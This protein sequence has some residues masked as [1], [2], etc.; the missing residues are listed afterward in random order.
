MTKFLSTDFPVDSI[1]PYIGFYPESQNIYKDSFPSYDFIEI[2]RYKDT[3]YLAAV[4][5]F[6][7]VV[8][9]YINN[10]K[11]TLESLQSTATASF[12][13]LFDPE[14]D[15]NKTI[16]LRLYTKII[17]AHTALHSLLGNYQHIASMLDFYSTVGIRPRN[18]YK[19]YIDA[20]LVSK[21]NTDIFLLLRKQSGADSHVGYNV[22]LLAALDYCDEASI[23]V[24]NIYYIGYDWNLFASNSKISLS[25]ITVTDHLRQVASRY[26]SFTLPNFSNLGHCGSCSFK[27][28]CTKNKFFG[29]PIK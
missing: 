23:G 28:S 29:K 19:T 3:P 2:E 11:L 7:K 22:K 20:V 27:L 17:E 12:F 6:D 15:V 24:Q 26:K 16:A 18:A 9:E 25:K 13:N 8:K 21:T 1:C 4:L 10:P 5:I 14:S